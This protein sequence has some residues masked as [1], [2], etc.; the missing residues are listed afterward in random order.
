M[1]LPDFNFFFNLS[2]IYRHSLLMLLQ[3]QSS[4]LISLDVYQQFSGS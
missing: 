1:S 4:Q 2:F 3:F